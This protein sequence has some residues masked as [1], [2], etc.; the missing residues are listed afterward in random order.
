[1][2]SV[3]LVDDNAFFREAMAMVLE[4]EGYAVKTAADVDQALLAI[5]RCHFD[6]IISDYDMPQKNGLDFLKLLRTEDVDTPFVMVSASDD[7]CVE[8][9]A[10]LLGAFGFITKPFKKGDL[11]N[12]V[13]QA[14]ASGANGNWRYPEMNIDDQDDKAA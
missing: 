2:R 10:L 8:A 6:V 5:E 9:E 4:P 13:S 3:L 12:T 1:M 11:I 7:V 14:L